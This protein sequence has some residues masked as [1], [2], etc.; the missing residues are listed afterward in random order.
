MAHGD[1]L[2][3]TPR[4][5]TEREEFFAHLDGLRSRKLAALIVPAGADATGPL[6]AYARERTDVAVIAA[7][8]LGTFAAVLREVAEAL[9]P[10]APGAARTAETVIASDAPV[11]RIAEWL[12]GNLKGTSVLIAV[13]R[14]GV[15]ASECSQ[16]AA[17]ADALSEDPAFD[18]TLCFVVDRETELPLPRWFAAERIEAPFILDEALIALESIDAPDF[19]AIE[20]REQLVGAL[21]RGDVTEIQAL[22]AVHG[23]DL[24]DRGNI[25]VVDRALEVIGNVD[26]AHVLILRGLRE[27]R[28][29]RTDTS[30]A[31]LRGAIE[32]APTPL[33]GAEA[34][35]RLARELV[36]RGRP[37]AAELIEPFADNPLL[38]AHMRSMAL[39]ILAQACA[40]S[41]RHADAAQ[42]MSRAFAASSFLSEDDRATLHARASF[43]ALSGGEVQSAKE[44]AEAAAT[45]AELAS[46][47]VVAF[48]AYSVLT[49]L[50]YDDQGP[51]AALQYLKLL[52]QCAT[53]AG[54]VDFLL[55]AVACIYENETERGNA[56]ALSQLNVRLREFDLI[57]EADGTATD[58][59][60]AGRAMIQAWAGDFREAFELLGPSGADQADSDR[61]AHRAAELAVYAAAAGLSGAAETWLCAYREASGDAP[62]G[63]LRTDRAAVLAWT[64]RALL[65]GTEVPL[66][67]RHPRVV[68]LAEAARAVLGYR[69]GTTN[70]A[71]VLRALGALSLADGGGYARMLGALPGAVA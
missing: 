38:P 17:F 58:S 64:A 67:V 68:P 65:G 46:L 71:E 19:R 45:L 15:R 9:R 32:R 50:A 39:S 29:G 57:Y 41:G 30:E 8:D 11:A 63:V 54:N 27:A 28:L 6:R 1:A 21:A 51:T 7:P 24:V 3:E 55:Y 5:R 70:A 60:I 53:R 47:D 61:R 62:C 10:W 33:V 48:G 4:A 49:V 22:V 44:H 23:L 59:V 43:V 14:C 56:A 37:D 66:V 25:A 26:E 31:W 2:T 13:A 12:A 18:G 36:R 52:E 20:P 16:L 40:V 35:S 34:A 42:A 69:T